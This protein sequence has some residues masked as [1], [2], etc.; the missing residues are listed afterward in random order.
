MRMSLRIKTVCAALAAALILMVAA[1][2]IS[3]QVYSNTIYEQYETMTMNLAKTEAVAVNADTVAVLRDAVLEIYRGICAE[4]GGVP[5]FEN[6][7]ETDWE[8]YFSRYAQVEEMPEYQETLKLLHQFS[9][10]NDIDSIYIGYMDVE[11][12]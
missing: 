4:S 7:T 3:Y 11:T 5:D 6:F 1:A 2:S 9:D 8:T 12:K 10:A